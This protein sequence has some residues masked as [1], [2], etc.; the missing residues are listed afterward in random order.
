MQRYFAINK[1]LDISKE[2]IHHITN[3]M[4]MKVN[5]NIEL[6]YEN[7]LYLCV[8]ESITKNNV[9]Y[10]IIS[11]NKIENNKEY[12]V[13]IAAS[14]I[15]NFDYMLQKAT[16]L[17]VD[18]II[19]LVANRNVIKINDNS[20]IDRW[21]KI[22][23]E[24]S[25]QCHRINMPVIHNITS[26]NNLKNYIKDVN[27]LCSVN[28]ATISIKEVMKNTNIHD[29]ILIVIGPE[30]G[31]TNEEEKILMEYGFISTTLGDNILRAETVPLYILSVINYNFMR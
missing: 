12:R 27:I 19:P 29:T 10:R 13:V 1:K 3:V 24:A 15:K 16:E 14:L 6:I 21:N 18:E 7:V 22:C 5:D 25:E 28:N 31:F 23:K 17:D 26:I 20:K 4:R 9:N 8:I 2:D 11:E 30:G